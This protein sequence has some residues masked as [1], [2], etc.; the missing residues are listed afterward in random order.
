[1]SSKAEETSSSNENEKEMTLGDALTQAK[2]TSL[3][4]VEELQ[5]LAGGADIKVKFFLYHLS[6]FF[7]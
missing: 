3:A 5:S 1:L 6:N 7:D 2:E 4:S